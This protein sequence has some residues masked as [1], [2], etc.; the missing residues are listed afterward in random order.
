MRWNKL[1]HLDKKTWPKCCWDILF[2]DG[3]KVWAGWLET[4]EESEDLVFYTPFME[5]GTRY[6]QTIENVTH[7]ADW[8]LPPSK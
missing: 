7:W 5:P 3:K 1:D 4:W 8:P 6:G 2:T